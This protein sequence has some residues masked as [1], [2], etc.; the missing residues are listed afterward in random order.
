MIATIDIP[1]QF[2]DILYLKTDV[3]QK[4]HMLIGVKICADNSIMVELQSGLACS[5]HYP[6]EVSSE[7]NVLMATTN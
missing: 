5:I 2:G 6:I 1:Y 7:K 3:D 4:P